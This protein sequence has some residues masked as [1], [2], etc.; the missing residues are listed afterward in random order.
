MP[1]A[2]PE[3][4]VEVSAVSHGAHRQRWVL[5]TQLIDPPGQSVALTWDAQAQLVVLTDSI[6]QVTTIVQRFS[7]FTG[8][9]TVIQ[10]TTMSSKSDNPAK[11]PGLRV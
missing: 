7:L 2:G 10:T 3:G 9:R 11:S 1:T 5:L 6:G 4:T 8:A